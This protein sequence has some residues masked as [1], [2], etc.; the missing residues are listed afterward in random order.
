MSPA[1]G[2]GVRNTTRHREAGQASRQET[3]RRL[4]EAAAA[5]FAENGYARATVTRIAARAGVTVQTLYL[6]W[7]SKRELLRGYLN[8]ALAGRADASYEEE[9]PRLIAAAMGGGAGDGRESVR[10][11]ARLFREFAERAA[12]GWRLYRDAAA[13]DPEIAA[14]WLA[15]QQLRR[16]TF[17]Q[18]VDRLPSGSL[19]SGL[20]AANATE[21]AW[22][23]AS[24]ETYDLMVRMAGHSLDEY[25]TWLDST[26]A[27]ALLRP[28][29]GAA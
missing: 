1:G 24:P 8:M 20:T 11:L 19:R 26:L 17:A 7:G 12:L 22:A 23:I 28:D 18:M 10:H 27:A 15:L 16:E 6:A 5:E 21:T 3:R 14:D 9:R 29:G 25:E 4:L 2:Q 13:A